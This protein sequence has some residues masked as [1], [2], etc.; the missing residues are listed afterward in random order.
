[1]AHFLRKVRNKSSLFPKEMWV[2]AGD[3]SY[4]DVKGYDLCR[5]IAYQAVDTHQL[6][7][8]Y[9]YG[10]KT[11]TP[12]VVLRFDT[13]E[14]AIEMRSKLKLSK[15][16]HDAAHIHLCQSEVHITPQTK[17]DVFVLLELLKS[18]DLGLGS[19]LE[20]I[21]QHL[22]LNFQESEP[23]L[24]LTEEHLEEDSEEEC[25][26]LPTESR[27]RVMCAHCG[28]TS[29]LYVSDSER[30]AECEKHKSSGFTC[31]SLHYFCIACEELGWNSS[32]GKGG[33][34]DWISNY[35]TKEHKRPVLSLGT[36]SCFM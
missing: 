20:S 28:K 18:E 30:R 12:I 17:L 3:F 6:S 35:K 27:K 33:G 14:H 4:Q 1:L 7:N 15:V 32:A 22:H 9:I 31:G 25:N 11:S 34:S 26:C 24:P 13:D 10:Y 36:L 5:Q 2:R 19:I 16:P 21:S 8:I 23:G 29:V